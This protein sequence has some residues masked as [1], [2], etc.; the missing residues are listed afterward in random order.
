MSQYP[1]H[2][3]RRPGLLV[4]AAVGLLAAACSSTTSAAA[5][6]SAAGSFPTSIAAANGTVH[7]TARPRAIISLSPTA[8]EMLFAIGAGGQVKAVDKDSDYPRSAPHTS[9]DGFQPNV[10]AIAAYRPDLVVMAGDTSGLIGRLRTLGIPVLSL[11]AATTLADS[12]NQFDELGAATGHV[13]QA[14][15]E[16]STMK[17]QIS[18][19]VHGAAVSH[20]IRTY[21]Y[22]LDPTYYSVTSST[23][24]GRVLSL[25]GLRNIADAAPGAAS[26]GGYPQLSSEFIVQ[27]SPDFI[28]LADSI[29]CGQSAHS[30][31]SRPGWSTVTAVQKGQIVTINDD[32]ASRWGPRIVDLLRIV[33]S[34][35]Q[36]HPSSR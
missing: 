1:Q 29:C 28:F 15:A 36:K 21:Y 31:A 18:R 23:F 6:A 2:A 25:L 19:I 8:T 13:H 20:A 12:Y 10:E 24:V 17:A 14:A 9:L 16:V 7:I 26:S 34:A 33:A 27:A 22:E 3:G 30:V 11:P 35:L 4:I 32:I 5:K